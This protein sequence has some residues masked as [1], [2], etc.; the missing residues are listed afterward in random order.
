[1]ESK[2]N[3][4]DL[5]TKAV[6]PVELFEFLRDRMTGYDPEQ[7]ISPRVELALKR[8]RNR[9]GTSIGNTMDSKWSSTHGTC[10]TKKGALE[11]VIPSGEASKQTLN[12]A[13]DYK[14]P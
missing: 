10:V 14:Q 7:Y 6:K 1:M 9:S 8:R 3:T 4:A 13:R 12:A 5:G 11:S 2:F